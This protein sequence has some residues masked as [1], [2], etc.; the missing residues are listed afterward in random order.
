MIKYFFRFVSFIFVLV[1]VI[2]CSQKTGYTLFISPEGSDSNP[3]TEQEPLASLNKARELVRQLKSKNPGQD[4]T[5]Y[6]RG[7]VY[8]ISKTIVFTTEDSGEP[9]QRIIYA[10]YP[11]ETP[12]LSAGVVVRDWKKP[13]QFPEEMPE[14][15]KKSV[16]VADVSF[17]RKTR[18]KQDPSPTVATQMK[19]WLPFF[20]LYRGNEKLTRARGPEFSM[21]R[22]SKVDVSDYKTLNFRMG[23]MKNRKDLYNAELHLIP[24]HIWIG[25]ILP[26]QAVD[27][28]TGIAHTVVPST[29]PMY[30]NRKMAY[31]DVAHVEN[32]AALL[33]EPGE[34]YLDK[35]SYLLYYWPPEGNPGKNIE[36]PVLTEIIRVEGKI[37]YD[38][39]TDVPVKNLVFKGLAFTHADRFPWHG[40]TGWGLQHDWERFDSPSSML[41]FRGAENCVVD[42]CH[43]TNAGS[44]GLRFDLYARH[45]RITG[46]RFDHLGGV[47]I[48]MAGYG[49]GTKDVNRDNE[50]SNNLIHNIGE[51]YWGSPALFVWQSGHNRIAH[52]HLFDLPYTAICVTGRIVWSPVKD[53]ECSHTIRWKEVKLPKYAWSYDGRENNWYQREPYLHSRNNIIYRNDI[54]NVT[55]ITGDGNAIYVSGAG[56]GNIVQENY[57]HDVYGPRMHTFIRCDDDQNLTT[58]T[59]N[60]MYKYYN[61]RGEGITSKGKNDII[62]NLIVDLKNSEVDRHRGYIVFP[63]AS[64]DSSVIKHN[65]LFSLKKGQF[66]YGQG[67]EKKRVYPVCLREALV[68]SNIYYSPAD[69]DFGTVHLKKE[70]PFGVDMHSIVEDPLFTDINRE[71]FSFRPGSPALKLGIAQPVPKDSVGLEPLYRQKYE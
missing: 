71:D 14:K 13:K 16:W 21:V 53:E 25:N 20:T 15:A 41:R 27:E 58:I 2:G 62:G 44:S 52:N 35:K 66:V 17:V 4:I 23:A 70:R 33:D 68:D 28:T 38:G 40:Q 43:F 51:L 10:A 5:V 69:P 60:V 55:Q 37:D 48:L 65:V 26:L 12:V 63:E 57:C 39:E 7:G 56:R 32:E 50:I 31:K 22:D 34:W 46:N 24:G 30:W 42:D 1:L 49:P 45:N 3:G 54:H 64:I 67:N 29:Y 8:H 11:G 61:G 18:E 6:L 9:G 47:A 59:G 19:R 36:V